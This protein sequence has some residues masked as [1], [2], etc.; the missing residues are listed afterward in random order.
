MASCLVSSAA[1]A[2]PFAVGGSV[3]P[4]LSFMHPD[5]E[6]EA[7]D[8]FIFASGESALALPGPGVAA[9]IFGELAL[10]PFLSL[11]T[12]LDYAFR[13]AYCLGTG[14]ENDGDWWR[15]QSNTIGLTLYSRFTFFRLAKGSLQADGGM[16]L[17]IM[18][19]GPDERLVVSGY[20]ID[21]DG[22]E[23]S[24][25]ILF[26]ARAGVDWEW[27]LGAASPFVL[28]TGLRFEYLFLTVRDPEAP[29]QL[30]LSAGLSVSFAYVNGG[31]PGSAKAPAKEAGIM[32]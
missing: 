5:T 24:G 21:V 23:N 28:R 13:D 20:A 30:P 7:V 15:L 17:G 10:F 12:E 31:K 3:R 22:S 18:P 29:F 32:P 9:G 1:V 11:G 16:Y 8:A 4:L 6:A 14:T 27:R 2:I 26:G 19:K 25:D